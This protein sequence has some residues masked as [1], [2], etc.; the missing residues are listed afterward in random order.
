MGIAP[1]I[2]RMVAQIRKQQQRPRNRIQTGQNQ[3]GEGE[4]FAA[5]FKA[6]RAANAPA[7]IHVKTSVEDILPGVKLTK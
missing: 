3:G 2:L 6:A 7:L 1:Q 4:D 5:A